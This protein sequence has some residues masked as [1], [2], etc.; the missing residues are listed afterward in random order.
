MAAQTKPAAE[1]PHEVFDLDAGWKLLQEYSK[2]PVQDMYNHAENI[3][4][5]SSPSPTP[6]ANMMLDAKGTASCKH[7][8]H[9]I[10]SITY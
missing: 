5:D 1:K 2:I 8:V 3:V 10:P 4:S 7:K 6:E 9:F